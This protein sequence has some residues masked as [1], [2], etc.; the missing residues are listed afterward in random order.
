MDHCR[1]KTELTTDELLVR[2]QVTIII[3]HRISDLELHL[4]V[5]GRVAVVVVVVAYNT[6]LFL[7][8]C[9]E[10]CLLARHLHK[11]F[12]T[13]YSKTSTVQ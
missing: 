13:F 4:V 10:I 1:K 11:T 3:I 8:L 6:T 12:N 7:S 5:V 2:V 9:R